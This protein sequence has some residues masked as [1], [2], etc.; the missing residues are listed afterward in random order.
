M[1]EKKSDGISHRNLVREVLGIRVDKPNRLEVDSAIDKLKRGKGEGTDQTSIDL[2]KGLSSENRKELVDMLGEWR[3]K[4]E[5]P[6][7]QLL[8]SLALIFTEGDTSK[9]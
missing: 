9:L 5:I 2:Y 3:E 7:E 6:Q 4:E 1:G 8:A